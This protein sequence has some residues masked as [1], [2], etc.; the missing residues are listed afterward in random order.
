MSFKQIAKMAVVTMGVM[1]IAN[2]LAGRYPGARKL[3]QG[4]V[5]SPV[6]DPKMESTLYTT[7]TF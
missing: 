3:F 1:F 2:Q 6:G 5:V 7:T 4:S